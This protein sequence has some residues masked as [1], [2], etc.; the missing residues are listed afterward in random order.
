MTQTDWNQ[1]NDTFP[2]T[3]ADWNSIFRAISEKNSGPN[4]PMTTFAFQWWM[5]TGSNTLFLRNNSNSGWWEFARLI[6]N[7]WTFEGI[8]QQNMIV[9]W[10]GGLNNIPS[11]W[12]I[13]DG[14]NG[15]INLVDFFIVGAGLDYLPGQVDG[16][17]EVTLNTAQIPPHVHPVS[18]D[19][20]D[21][22]HSHSFLGH[23]GSAGSGRSDR[24]GDPTTKKTNIAFTGFSIN[25]EVDNSGR[26]EPHENRPPYYSVVFIQYTG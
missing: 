24:D 3:L 18:V 21:P 16:E 7:R 13:C 5:D 6:N 23:S 8:F 11:G 4:E 25:V 15:T 20:N 17:N 12:S 2:N 10:A 26:G 19:I 1:A 14:T 22:G 9:M